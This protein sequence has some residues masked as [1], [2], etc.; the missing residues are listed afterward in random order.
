M[1]YTST[2]MRVVIFFLRAFSFPTQG[3]VSGLSDQDSFQK[4]PRAL[5]C[6]KKAFYCDLAPGYILFLPSLWIHA[7]FMLPP[8]HE[9]CEACRLSLER[10]KNPFFSL[11]PSLSS[12]DSSSPSSSLAS[13]S[14]SSSSSASPDFSS[15]VSRLRESTALRAATTRAVGA[16]KGSLTGG[17]QEEEGCCVAVNVFFRNLS[18]PAHMKIYSKKDIYGN[19][20][21][22]FGCPCLSFSLFRRFL[23]CFCPGRCL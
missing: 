7:V 6:L 17:A 18:L 19:K 14:S 16:G 12:V 2:S 4:F 5:E 23:L 8:L 21:R 1:M 9:L 20:V 11:C 22:L 10:T 3:L 15:S 13:A